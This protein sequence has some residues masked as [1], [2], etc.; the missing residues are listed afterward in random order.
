MPIKAS[1]PKYRMEPINTR[2][3]KTREIT[4]KNSFHHRRNAYIRER[5]QEKAKESNLVY[6]Q[7][8]LTFYIHADLRG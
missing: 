4:I 5:M 3:E 1:A 6:I 8:Y 2:E 7:L